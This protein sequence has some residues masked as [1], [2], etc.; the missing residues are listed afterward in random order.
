MIYRPPRGQFVTKPAQSLGALCGSIERMKLPEISRRQAVAAV[1]VTLIVLAACGKLIESGHSSPSSRSTVGL[2]LESSSSSARLF[3]DV[4]GAVK[5]PGLYRLRIGARVNDALIEA[6]GATAAADLTLVNLAA[7]LTDG[8]QVLV[9]AKVSPASVGAPGATSSQ[10]AANA[11]VHL[12]SATLEQLD[13]LPGVGPTTA[14]RIIDYRTQHGP[15][16]NV[17]E[18]DAVSGI[19]PAKLGELRGLVVP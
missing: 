15:F 17:D 13:A 14:Q 6:G 11:P 1:V 7:Q 5:R 4:A 10:G 18:L 9:P 3:V 19:G 2:K 12:N 16:A 8:E